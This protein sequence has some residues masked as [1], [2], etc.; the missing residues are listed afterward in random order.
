M[1]TFSRTKPYHIYSRA[2]L[3]LPTGGKRAMGMAMWVYIL[4]RA[5][6]VLLKRARRGIPANLLVEA[7]A[8]RAFGARCYETKAPISSDILLRQRC[9][10]W[11]NVASKQARCVCGCA[12]GGFGKGSSALYGER[13]LYDQEETTGAGNVRQVRQASE[14]HFMPTRSP[15]FTPTFSAPSPSFTMWPTPSCPPT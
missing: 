9:V 11:R 15:T 5:E 13:D 2:E 1:T 3:L 8:L 14:I 4:C 10:A 7:E 12:L 6:N